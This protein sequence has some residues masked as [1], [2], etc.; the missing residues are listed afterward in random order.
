MN[1]KRL[2][3]TIV[4]LAIVIAVIAVLTTITLVSYRIIR[5]Q[6]ADTAISAE[7]TDVTQKLVTH[8]IANNNKYPVTLSEI[9]VTPSNGTTLTYTPTANQKSYKLIATNGSQSFSIS[10]QDRAPKKCNKTVCAP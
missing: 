7:I 3:F 1:H 10:D 8:S 5:D 6:A 2:G 4:E 9:G